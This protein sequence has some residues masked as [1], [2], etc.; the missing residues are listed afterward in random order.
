MKVLA[1]GGRDFD[2]RD[3]VYEYLDKLHSTQPVSELIEGG[4]RGAD[5]L[6]GEWA[7]DRGVLRRIFEANWEKY[8]AAAGPIR[9]KQMLDEGKPNLVVAFPGGKGTAN[10]MKQALEAGVDVQEIDTK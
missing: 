7:D 4:A 1:C 5:S 3:K 2:N 8:R 9:N 10:M 6:A